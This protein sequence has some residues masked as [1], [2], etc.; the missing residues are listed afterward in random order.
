MIM[1][2]KAEGKFKISQREQRAAVGG[3]PEDQHHIKDR[4]RR[5]RPLRESQETKRGQVYMKERVVNGVK[6]R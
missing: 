4:L 6:C 5:R 2:A 1:K 3:K